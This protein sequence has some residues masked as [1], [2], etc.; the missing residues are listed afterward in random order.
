[1]REEDLDFL[2]YLLASP[3]L[4]GYQGCGIKPVMVGC[5]HLGLDGRNEEIITSPVVISEKI[6]AF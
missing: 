4:D 1:M 3:H 5:R 6:R 2:N